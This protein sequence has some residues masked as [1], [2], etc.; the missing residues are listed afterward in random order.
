MTGDKCRGA[1]FGEQTAEGWGANVLRLQYST[2]MHTSLQQQ[3]I[4]KLTYLLPC[5]LCLLVN[6]YAHPVKKSFS[7]SFFSEMCQNIA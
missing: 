1:N 2:G 6:F 4:D 7:C 5:V 3:N